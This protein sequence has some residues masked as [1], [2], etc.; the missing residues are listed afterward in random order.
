MGALIEYEKY[1]INELKP[2]FEQAFDDYILPPVLDGVSVFLEKKS[3]YFS[4]VFPEDYDKV[5]G[6]IE[7]IQSGVPKEDV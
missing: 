3:H 7:K 1:D 2:Y 6:K 4:S 5:M